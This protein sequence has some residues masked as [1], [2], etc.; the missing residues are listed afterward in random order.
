KPNS[1]AGKNCLCICDDVIGEDPLGFVKQIN[2][3]NKNG[4]CIIVSNLKNEKVNIELQED[5]ATEISISKQ[6]NEISVTKK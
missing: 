3:C 2:E 1:C 4:V 5:F 6:N